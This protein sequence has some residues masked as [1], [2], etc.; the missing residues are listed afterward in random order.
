[1][2]EASTS[3]MD[4]NAINLFMKD[5]ALKSCGTGSIYNSVHAIYISNITN[6]DGP[7]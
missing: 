1:M 6:T 7:A 3:P 2:Q 4:C 5:K